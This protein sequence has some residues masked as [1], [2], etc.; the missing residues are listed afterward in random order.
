MCAFQHKAEAERVMISISRLK[1]KSQV[2][3]HFCTRFPSLNFP[4]MAMEKVFT[5][6]SNF[7]DA[8]SHKL[9]RSLKPLLHQNLDS[10]RR[11]WHNEVAL[12][13]FFHFSTSTVPSLAG[14]LNHNE[15]KNKLKFNSQNNINSGIIRLTKMGKNRQT[16][17]MNERNLMYDKCSQINI[18]HLLSTLF[19]DI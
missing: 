7:G 11:I 19:G 14:S 8:S 2:A 1:V 18:L 12:Y 16:K 6:S 5:L 15:K 9:S 3:K 17:Q 4:S 13:G 10:L